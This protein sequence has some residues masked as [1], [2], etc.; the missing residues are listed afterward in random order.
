M[1]YARVISL[2]GFCS[3]LVTAKLNAGNE[4]QG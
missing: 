2:V 1:D 4:A 3:E